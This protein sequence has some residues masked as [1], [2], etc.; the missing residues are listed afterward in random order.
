MP[1]VAHGEAGVATPDDTATFIAAATTM[2]NNALAIADIADVL[3]KY[4]YDT[5]TL[6]SERDSIAAF[7]LATRAQ[8]EALAALQ[9][10]AAQYVK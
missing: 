10:W 3:A 7:K 4:G 6:H 9:R 8:A 1:W 5:T 2:F